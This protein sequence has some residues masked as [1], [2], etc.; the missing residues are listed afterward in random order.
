MV[1]V[2]LVLVLVFG[3]KKLS[4]DEYV[5]G[6]YRWEFKENYEEWFNIV[7]FDFGFGIV[8]CV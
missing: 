7:K 8:V 6:V 1:V 5:S 2:I 4:L 3:Y